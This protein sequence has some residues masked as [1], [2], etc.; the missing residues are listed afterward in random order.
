MLTTPES[1]EIFANRPAAVAIDGTTHAGKSSLAK[2]L[3]ETYNVPVIAIG[4]IWRGL[5]RYLLDAGMIKQGDT[6]DLLRA[7]L[8]PALGDLYEGDGEAEQNVWEI[9]DKVGDPVKTYG[10]K[11]LRAPD[12]AS[13]V[14]LF[15]PFPAIR[16]AVRGGITDR[17]VDLYIAQKPPLFVVA[18]GRNFVPLIEA[19]KGTAF[20]KLALTCDPEEAARRQCL[21]RGQDPAH[22]SANFQA[23]LANIIKRTATD[24]SSTV[25]PPAVEADAIVYARSGQPDNHRSHIR[26]GVGVQATQENRQV[27]IETSRLSLENTL[28]IGRHLVAEALEYHLKQSTPHP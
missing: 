13:V 22:D 24:A 9:L 12:V 26:R 10:E 20:L 16:N 14:S 6:P 27:H 8:E 25:H 3:G 19:A 2:D 21:Y 4:V 17:V 18:D 7:K 11:S 5:S 28:S 1:V 15:S 23:S